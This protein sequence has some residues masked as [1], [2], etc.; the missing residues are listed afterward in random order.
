MTSLS[1]GRLVLLSIL[2]VELVL[3]A[4]GAW[5]WTS[6]TIADESPRGDPPT[7]PPEVPRP[8]TLETGYPLVAERARG[9][10]EQ[11][12]LILVSGQLDWPLD[13]PP[14]PLRE[15]P[16]GGWLTYVFVRDREGQAESLSMLVERYSG[17]VVQERVAPWGGPA[18]AG[19]LDLLALPTSSTDAVVAAEAAGG[20]EFRRACPGARHQTRISLGVAEPARDGAGGS[21]SAATPETAPDQGERGSPAAERDELIWILGYRDVRD[22]GRAP[23]LVSVGASTGA[24]TVEERLAFTVESCPA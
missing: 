5:L 19:N 3:A 10:D 22:E 24:V 15:L 9:W 14:G 2:A 12:R 16:G 7:L 23:L 11:A 20:T 6:A 21:D 1:R 13:V 8:L 18:P 4:A 17:T